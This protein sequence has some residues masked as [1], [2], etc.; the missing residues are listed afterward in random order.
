MERAEDALRECQRHEQLAQQALEDAR[1]TLA[2]YIERL[3]SLIEQLYVDCIGHLV[4]LQFIQDKAYDEGKLRARVAEFKAEVT[5]AEKALAAA[6]EAVR[7]AQS[8]LNKERVKLEAMRDL[9][10]QE[11]IQ[12]SIAEGRSLAKTLDDLSGSK[13]ARGL[14]KAP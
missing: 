13:F 5:D 3:P 2:H 14:R 10:K 6:I 12:I 1:L 11:R 4:S 9:I 8:V 7:D